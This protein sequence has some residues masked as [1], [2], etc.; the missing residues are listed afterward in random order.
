MSLL[1]NIREFLFEAE[2]EIDDKYLLALE[3]NILP[4]HPLASAAIDPI[5]KGVKHFGK[6]VGILADDARNKTA[7]VFDEIIPTAVT[8]VHDMGRAKKQLGVMIGNHRNER[9]RLDALD[10]KL[11]GSGFAER[12]RLA[13]IQRHADNYQPVVTYA[14]KPGYIDAINN[15]RDSTASSLGNA[16]NTLKRS[17]V[18]DHGN[19]LAVQ[20][21]IYA[22][23]INPADANLHDARPPDPSK[24]VTDDGVSVW[25]K[26]ASGVGKAHDFIAQNPLLVGSTAGAVLGAGLLAKYKNSIMRGQYLVNHYSKLASQAKNPAEKQKYEQRL[27]WAKSK[28]ATAQSKARIEHKNFIEKSQRLKAR[29]N[30]LNKAGRKQEAVYLQKR[31][32]RRQKFLSKI[33]ATI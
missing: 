29:I 27:N 8:G 25:S 4:G 28:L 23:R 31:L 24:L 5:A 6:N 16:A 12:L 15:I 2:I 30:E 22:S 32:D 17:V 13:D 9:A 1:N 19:R 10:N 26:M 7:S 18:N 14:P 33:G 20:N 3:A 21:K 11:D